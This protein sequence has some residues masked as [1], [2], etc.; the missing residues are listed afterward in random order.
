MNMQNKLYTMQM[1]SPPNN[2]FTASPQAVIS[3]P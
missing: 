3:E 1:F 2:Q